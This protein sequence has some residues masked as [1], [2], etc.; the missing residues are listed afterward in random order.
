MD[1]SVSVKGCSLSTEH[2]THMSEDPHQHH[3][4]HCRRL[5]CVLLVLADDVHDLPSPVLVPARERS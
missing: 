1:V 2:G 4:L 5:P 3:H